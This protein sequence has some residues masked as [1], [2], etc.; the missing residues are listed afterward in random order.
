M[1]CVGKLLSCFV[2]ERK[3]REA[4]AAA[5]C[6]FRDFETT[7]INDVLAKQCQTIMDGNDMF[8]TNC[9]LN[10]RPHNEPGLSFETAASCALSFGQV[11]AGDV[12]WYDAESCGKVKFAIAVG[13]AIFVVVDELPAHVSDPRL[14]HKNRTTRTIVPAQA[15]VAVLLWRDECDVFIRISLPVQ[16]L[17]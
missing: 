17:L 4:K 12:M 2:T 11:S 7:L 10:A 13:S 15:A 14:R 16:A 8:R 3:H 9:L 1:E 6:V 5:S